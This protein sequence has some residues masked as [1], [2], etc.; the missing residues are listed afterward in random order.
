MAVYPDC[1]SREPWRSST[2]VLV[3]LGEADDI[4]LPQ[5]CERIVS[6]LPGETDVLLHR[7]LGA[8]H[9]FDLTEGPERLDIGG[10]LTLGRNQEAGEA[11][12]KEIF[13]FLEGTVRAP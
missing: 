13:R 7:Y 5:R 10:G 11:A 9:G 3:L 2:P 6:Q 12:W 1:D 8:R 4:A